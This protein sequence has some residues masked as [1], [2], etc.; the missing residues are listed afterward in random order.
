MLQEKQAMQIINIDKEGIAYF[1]AHFFPGHMN[2][3]TKW[4][5]IILHYQD[6]FKLYQG[7]DK[8][9]KGQ[10][11]LNSDTA[12][13]AA[14]TYFWTL[15]ALLRQRSERIRELQ[16]ADWVAT[17]RGLPFSYLTV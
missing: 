17:L 5:V 2:S 15:I 10:H 4:Y 12:L 14:I 9:G 8:Q 1:T 6:W 11:L 13:E 3:L 7:I 16:H